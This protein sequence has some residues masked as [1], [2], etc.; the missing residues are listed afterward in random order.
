M[1]QTLRFMYYHIEIV[2]SLQSTKNA[3]IVIS[4]Q[5][6]QTAGLFFVC[7]MTIVDYYRK[8]DWL[9][10]TLLLRS[11]FQNADPGNAK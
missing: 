11:D 9:F 2:C 8:A 7:F 1:P 6:L 5:I 3:C 10:I 4:M